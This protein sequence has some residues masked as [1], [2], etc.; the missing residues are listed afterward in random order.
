MQVDHAPRYAC[1]GSATRHSDKDQKVRSRTPLTGSVQS[2]PTE[3]HANTQMM[4]AQVDHVPRCTCKGSATR[5]SDKDQR[6]RSRTP[7]NWFSAVI[8]NR[9][10]YNYQMVQARRLTMSQ[11]YRCEG[12]ATRYSDKDQKA[13]S[14]TP[15]TDVVQSLPTE[16]RATTR[17]CKHAD[18][19]CRTDDNMKAQQPDD[20]TKIRK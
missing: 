19:R 17:L 14:R 1:K 2:L 5:H 3:I 10:A 16:I 8:A 6:V 7:L 13:R 20:L 9:D 11:N 4:Q 18:C 12:S 15:L